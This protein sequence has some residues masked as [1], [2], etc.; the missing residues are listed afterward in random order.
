MAKRTNPFSE[1]MIRIQ[2]ELD[3][4]NKLRVRIGVQGSSGKNGSGQSVSADDGILMIAGV[5]EYGLTI[6]P[7]KAKNLAIPLKRELRD[8]SPRDI[9][10]TWILTTDTG[11][12]F[13][14]KD[15]G[16]DQID[17]L[18]MLV[19]S[20]NI[21]ERSF[22]RGS[23]DSGRQTLDDIADKAIGKIIK[24]KWTARQ[25]ADWFG[26]QALQMTLDYFNTQLKPKSNTTL[27]STN[28]H[29]P[30]VESGRLYESITYVIE[31]VG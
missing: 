16:K 21:P 25:A 17:F 8:K 27:A 15:K 29:A 10:N 12:V 22:I 2:R 19:P 18:Y 3:A 11:H 30:L 1:D 5:H 28:Q 20:V 6:K 9:R 4:L 23:Y 13:I 7:K 26:A 24:E 14:V 31:E